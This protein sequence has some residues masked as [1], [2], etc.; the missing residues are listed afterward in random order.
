M[1]EVINLN[2]VRKARAKAEAAKDADNNRVLHG[3]PKT[4]KKKTRSDQQ[5]SQK[6]HAGKKLDKTT[7]ELDKDE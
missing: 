1:G 7:S 6:T 4:L 2:Q 5:K 3:T